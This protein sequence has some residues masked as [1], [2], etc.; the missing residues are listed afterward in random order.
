M[1][2]QITDHEDQAE[3]RLPE[4]FKDKTKKSHKFYLETV[5]YTKL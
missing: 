5:F 2:T 1:V 3:A 4:Q